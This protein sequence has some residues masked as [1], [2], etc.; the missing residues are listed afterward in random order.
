M[1][2]TFRGFFW[3]FIIKKLDRLDSQETAP[4]EAQEIVKKYNE[5]A[6]R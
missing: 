3:L 1:S 2:R 5:A 4:A 6:G